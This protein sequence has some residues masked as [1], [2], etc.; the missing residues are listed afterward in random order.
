M[1]ENKEP[2]QKAQWG[3]KFVQCSLGSAT[4]SGHKINLGL[5]TVLRDAWG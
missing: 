3:Q 1:E 4:G 5:K 2:E